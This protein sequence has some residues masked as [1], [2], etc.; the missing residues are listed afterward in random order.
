MRQQM[1]HKIAEMDHQYQEIQDTVSKRDLN[2]D[3]NVKALKKDLLNS[4]K[5]KK[6]VESRIKDLNEVI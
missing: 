1:H 3:S 2:T 6:S 5:E 4:E